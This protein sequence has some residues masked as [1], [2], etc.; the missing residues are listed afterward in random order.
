MDK[1]GYLGKC[2]ESYPKK[3]FQDYLQVEVA[4]EDKNGY[5]RKVYQGYP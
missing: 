1:N 3:G 2:N 4:G 5:L